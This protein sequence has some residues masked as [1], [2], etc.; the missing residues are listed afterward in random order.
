MVNFLS[1]LFRIIKNFLQD[2]SAHSSFH[3]NTYPLARNHELWVVSKL[4]R[5]W[6]SEGVTGKKT[7]QGGPNCPITIQDV[8]I[9]NSV[10]KKSKKHLFRTSSNKKIFLFQ[11][12]VRLTF[13]IPSQKAKVTAKMQTQY[14]L[15]CIPQATGIQTWLF[16]LQTSCLSWAWHASAMSSWILYR[17]DCGPRWDKK[18]S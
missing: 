9:K 11:F 14:I 3:A 1:R 8:A 18:R 6:G 15:I 2:Q 12:L 5:N 7:K 16:C 4:T 17:E 13:H 10:F